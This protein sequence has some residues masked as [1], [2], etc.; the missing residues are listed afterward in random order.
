MVWGHISPET[1]HHECIAKDIAVI[2][3]RVVG[4]G[5]QLSIFIADCAI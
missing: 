1:S 3:H 5:G 2:L 4:S